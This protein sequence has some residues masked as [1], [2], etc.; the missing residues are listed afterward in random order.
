MEVFANA[1]PDD[2][3][4]E[5]NAIENMRVPDVPVTHPHAGAASGAATT[6]AAS[7][8]RRALRLS[9][10]IYYPY[11]FP[12]NLVSGSIRR[13]MMAAASFRLMGLPGLYLLSSPVPSSKPDFEITCA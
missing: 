12:L 3:L 11:V 5:I 2:A 13:A 9:Y 1:L 7:L 4:A 10:Y 6:G 8:K